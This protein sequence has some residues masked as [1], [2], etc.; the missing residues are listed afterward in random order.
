MT[1]DGGWVL[2]EMTTRVA[3]QRHDSLT[4]TGVH[5]LEMRTVLTSSRQIYRKTCLVP[6]LNVKVKGKGQGHQTQKRH[7]F[8]QLR[9]PVKYLGN[10]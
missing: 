6:S 7:F 1:G 5:E 2:V 10:R 3:N 4:A 9:R 8:G